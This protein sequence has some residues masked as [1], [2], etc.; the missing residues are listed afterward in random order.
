MKTSFAK[1]E[2]EQSI[3]KR[4]ERQVELYPERIALKD[5]LQS[6][7]FTEVQRAANRIAAYLL[8]RQGDGAEAVAILFEH[9]PA[10]IVAILAVLKAGK[11]YVPLDPSYPRAN[12][13][14]M[15]KDSEAAV[16][17]ADHATLA[18]AGKLAEDGITVINIDVVEDAPPDHGPGLP[19]RP[20]AFACILYTSGSTG[21]PKGIVH[22]HRTILHHIWSHTQTFRIGP[23]DRQ[24]LLLSYSYA[25]SVS[26]IF[27]ALL[28]GAALSLNYVKKT[29]LENLARWLRDEK[30][31]TFKLPIALFRLFLN[32]MQDR[33]RT[34]PFPD[35]RLVVL[36]GDRL[37]RTDVE[38]FR[39]HFP[40]DCILVNRLASTEV[41]TLA[42]FIIDKTTVLTEQVVPV[43][44]PDADKEVLILDEDGRQVEAGET[45]EIVVASRYLSPGYWRLPEL[46]ADK[47][48]V[49]ATHAAGR[50]FYTGDL[51]R[52]GPDGCLEH[53]G[54][55]DDLVKIRGYRI[56]LSS[57]E[58]ALNALDEVKEAV[59]A[60]CE[61][62]KSVGGKKL[63]A[64][65]IPADPAGV[66]VSRLRRKL[67]RTLP[68]HM[69][70]VNYVVLEKFP[71]TPSGKIDRLAL[72]PPQKTRPLLDTSYVAPRTPAEQSIMEIWAEAL[73]LENVGVLDNFFDLGGD[74][75]TLL[76]MHAHIQE[77]FAI[78]IPI[79]NL[80]K[81][82]TVATLA[83]FI[84]HL[85]G[86]RQGSEPALAAA[87]SLDVPGPDTLPTEKDWDDSDARSLHADI[88]IIGMAG[89]FPDAGDTDEFW[90]NIKNG[91][92]SLHCYSDEELLAAGVD[93]N[94]LANPDYVKSGTTLPGIEE[95]DAAFFGLTP[96]E[97]AVLDPQHRLLLETAWHALENGGYPPEAFQGRVGIYAGAS[98]SVYL[99]QHILPQ[100]HRL[101]EVNDIRIRLS[102]DPEF[103]TTRLAY[104]LNLKGPAINVATA[105]ST[106]LV[107]VHLACHS[108]L[109]NECELALAGGVSVETPQK[110]GYLYQ[111]GWIFSPD[112]CC[113]PFDAAACGTV[114][115]NGAGL[116][117]LKRLSDAV[118]DGDTIHAVIKGSA[119]NN[120]GAFKMGFTAPSI[121]GQ[122]AVIAE[123]QRNAGVKPETIS[124]VETHGTGTALGDPIE[125][126]AL[127]QAF[128]RFTRKTG[129]CAV[130]SVKSNI[131]H[132]SRAA[133]IAGLL[134]TVLALEHRQI[135]PSL[136]F[137]CPNPQIDFPESPFYV[138]TALKPWHTAAGLPRRAGISSLG[139]GGT[140]THLI[141]EEWQEKGVPAPSK[142]FQLLVWSAKTETALEAATQN[143]LN[144]LRRNRDRELADIAFTLQAGRQ[145]FAC[146][147][148]LVCRDGDEALALLASPSAPEVKSGR[149]D[150]ANPA[151]VFMFPGEGTRYVDM[152][153]DLY[154][155][156]PAFRAH[157]D[158]AADLFAPA[159]GLDLREA[160]FP[161]KSGR[162][163]A[164]NL[165]TR[166]EIGRAAVFAVE[167]ALAR[168]LTGWGIYPEAL[169]GNG[170]GEYAA[171]CLSGVMTLD[172][173]PAVLALP[174]GSGRMENIALRPPIIPI[175]SGIT[176]GCLSPQEATDSAY[177][178]RPLSE[179]SR[180]RDG[181]NALALSA[182]GILLEV[183]PDGKL[184]AMFAESHDFRD[185][186]I[187]AALP[188][189]GAKISARQVLLRAVGQMWLR[190][191][192]IDWNGVHA[193][194]PR[195]RIPLPPYPFEKKRYWI[196]RPSAASA[197]QKGPLLFT[198]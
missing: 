10:A 42:R 18:L 1:T 116:V 122:T 128:R 8:N 27:G 67:A 119:V 121:D 64:Y 43:G 142:P 57:V 99:Q 25:A 130:G 55:K 44:E 170:I 30:I 110:T 135:P 120:D 72:P 38:S 69:I 105:C 123:A 84:S 182:N 126:A 81:H 78:D 107:A 169:I 187:L 51:G 193:H 96:L 94:L 26:E 17:L 114:I 4:F 179:R 158:Q 21:L 92:S 197:P 70:P 93:K 65:L 164:T 2:I 46:N 85:S 111:E 161:P 151:L 194:E 177:W 5:A 22:S 91:V 16:I 101:P 61:A 174:A 88:A 155:Q 115:G 157:I 80:F 6:Q 167:Y 33:V 47:F 103:L 136:N 127:T 109:R 36:G 154:R 113:R 52:I 7:S 124:Y 162:K 181:L 82:P 62:A 145:A 163:K 90:Q 68:N 189:A 56:V 34:A 11:Y 132:A 100:R 53:F 188:A 23:A 131:G 75:L 13:R 153:A 118:R 168:L 102:N 14:H 192:P 83:R 156:E 76:W 49:R 73:G 173:M 159:V 41:L 66:S 160:L 140:N 40:A 86:L 134:K 32:T 143:L 184:E 176:G 150:F 106:S 77:T 74:S 191:V 166:K 186:L 98:P 12:I 45:G 141:V 54:R 117:L 97:A 198:D 148:M 172:E 133:G 137:T 125:M 152:A 50:V 24:A 29:G 87:R 108:L 138:S 3:V 129:F 59:V 190:G 178:R 95:F 79:V 15:L 195:R 19:I 63:V 185:A 112:G 165:M 31:T 104:K 20:D 71:R 180:F 58:T 196:P 48:R 175:V 146:R 39:R 89:T 147:R 28:N 9:G 183:G 144:Y 35:L 171:A 60:V 139:I 149:C 37:L